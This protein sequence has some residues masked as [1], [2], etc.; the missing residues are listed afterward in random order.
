MFMSPT[1]SHLAGKTLSIRASHNPKESNMDDAEDKDGDRLEDFAATTKLNLLALNK[2]SY[3]QVYSSEPSLLTM[4]AEDE[5]IQSPR[6]RYVPNVKVSNQSS[7]NTG[8][9][10]LSGSSDE[11]KEEKTT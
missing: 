1:H 10:P 4:R 7:H 9:V 6:V 11:S 3:V 5:S 8:E 2:E